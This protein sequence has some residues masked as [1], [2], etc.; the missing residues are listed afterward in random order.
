ME[1]YYHLLGVSMNATPEEIKAAYK[2]RAK[3][4]HPDLHQGSK[5]H[6][7]Y[8]KQIL[9]AYQ[10]LSDTS[11]RNK[12][13]IKLFYGAV[14]QKIK[15]NN[16]VPPRPYGAA[17]EAARAAHN[18]QYSRGQASTKKVKEKPSYVQSIA[19]SLLILSSLAMLLYWFT[20]IMNR[21]HAEKALKDGLVAEAIA[22]DDTYAPANFAMGILLRDEYNEPRQALVF[23]EK[24]ITHAEKP[25]P[26]YYYQ[27][28]LCQVRMKAYSLAVADLERVTTM[29]PQN[30]TAWY[31]LGD[32]QLFI[33]DNP[34]KAI[35]SFDKVLSIK[36]N[37]FNALFGK[38][39]AFVQTR[40]YEQADQIFDKAAKVGAEQ[41]DLYY[42]WGFAKIG[43][44][45][46]LQACEMWRKAVDLGF[47]A[48]KIPENI[49][50]F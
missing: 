30:D 28:A 21:S 18:Q 32:L 13:D 11:A 26:N 16:D 36:S 12:Y 23:F 17:S 9:E 33:L 14:N 37:H 46:T 31:T 8:F 41:S 40:D 25:I 29:S 10:T 24:A 27:R 19:I 42:Y 1:N 49:K 50:C 38:A 20:Q 15:G 35:T 43:Q 45:D 39:Y 2:R 7:E 44:N 6:E 22:Y 48:D 47:N 34:Q 5:F 3:E 4:F